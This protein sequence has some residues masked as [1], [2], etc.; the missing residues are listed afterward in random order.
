MLLHVY[1]RRMISS[2]PESE[3]TVENQRQEKGLTEMRKSYLP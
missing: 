1:C 3:I 2:E